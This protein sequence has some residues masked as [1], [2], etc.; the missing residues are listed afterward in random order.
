MLTN[1]DYSIAL[2]KQQLAE[3]PTVVY[4]GHITVVDK[5]EMIAPAIAA[6]RREPVVGFDT[7]TKPAFKKGQSHKVALMQVAGADSCFLFRLNMTG[8]TDELVEW[9]SD[10]SCLKVGLSLKDDFL[11]LHK[12]RE[13]EPQGFIELQ[14]MVRGYHITDASLQ[15]IFG[16]IFGKRISKGQRLSNWEAESLGAGQM[17]YA[18]ID[19]WACLA[20]YNCLQS[21]G[22][23]PA[24]SPYIVTPDADGQLSA[25]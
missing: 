15:K 13:F 20:I 17:S 7:E 18:A 2:P 14:S 11:M 23:N 21:G 25:S 9:L 1:T 3:M 12:H 5:V 19:A 16:I 8:L 10:G 6:L 4:D 24:V 22:F